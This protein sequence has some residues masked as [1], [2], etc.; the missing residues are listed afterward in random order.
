[1]IE[2]ENERRNQG[3]SG[4]E[5]ESVAGRESASLRSVRHPSSSLSGALLD[6]HALSPASSSLSR[7]QRARRTANEEED[8]KRKKQAREREYPEDQEEKQRNAKRK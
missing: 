2:E 3:Q 6:Q 5:R 8:E 7:C 1:M 4:Q